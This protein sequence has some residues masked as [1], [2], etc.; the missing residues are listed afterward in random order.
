[1][2]QKSRMTKTTIASQ[3]YF[4]CEA[5]LYPPLTGIENDTQQ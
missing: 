4:F 5:I 1:M 3:F 2:Q